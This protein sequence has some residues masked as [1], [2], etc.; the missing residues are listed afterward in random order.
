MTITSIFYW[1]WGF[2]C[3]SWMLITLVKFIFSD[4]GTLAECIKYAFISTGPILFTVIIAVFFIA[5]H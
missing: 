4:A 5:L 2:M 3:I 1:L